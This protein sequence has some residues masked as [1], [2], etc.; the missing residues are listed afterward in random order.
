VRRLTRARLAAVLAACALFLLAALVIALVTGVTLDAAGDRRLVFLDLA[1]VLGGAPAGDPEAQIFHLSRL[2]RALAGAVAGAGLAA[3]GVAFQALLRNPL[4][5]PYTLGVSSGAA[6][7]AVVAIRLGLEPSLFAF[8][9]SLAAVG[10]VWRL[11]RVGRSRPAATLLLAGITLAFVCSAATMLVQYSASFQESYRIVRWMMG[12]LDWIPAA[13]LLRSA[14]VVAAA[15]GVLLYLARDLNALAAGAEAAASVGVRVERAI[16]LGYVSASLVVG[17][18]IAF[19]GPIGFV[20]IIVPHALRALV[21]PDHRALLPAAVL[22]GAGF[23][24]L[25]DTGA[26]TLLA[27]E[28]LPVGVITALLG[29]PFFLFLLVSEK[30]RSRLWG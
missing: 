13:E 6:L 17:A 3:A 5:E 23:V 29:G 20:G 2:P 15:L 1:R 27:P 30:G 12:G 7:G 24:M 10:V 28:Q 8:A 11:A 9:G 25:A 4:A 14:A 22:A 21:G 18:V 26:R 16:G 19:A